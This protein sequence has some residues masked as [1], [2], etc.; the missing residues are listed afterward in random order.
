MGFSVL[1]YFIGS[2]Y[3][4]NTIFHVSNDLTLFL[5]NKKYI[6]LP[7]Y[8][9]DKINEVLYSSIH[10]ILVSFLSFLCFS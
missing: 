3:I 1:T 6:N 7:M 9:F 8:K 2:F 10:C 4:V 5:F